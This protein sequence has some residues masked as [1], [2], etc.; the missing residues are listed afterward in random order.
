[1]SSLI[2][3]E[4]IC[5]VYLSGE[6][7]LYA[8]DHV[9]LTINHGEL[10]AIMGES[11]AGKS[12]LMDIVGLLDEPT[13]GRYRLD[14]NNVEKL[15]SNE[16]AEIRNRQIGFVFQSFFLLPRMT[17]VQNVAMPLIYRGIRRHRAEEYA[18][19]IMQKLNIANFKDHKPSQMS[20][21]EQQ[22]VAISRAL[23]GNPGVLLADE[24]TGALDSKTGKEILNLFVELQKKDHRTI[25]VVTHDAAVGAQCERIIV[26]R[27]GKLIDDFKN[28][29]P[30]KEHVADLVK[31]LM[32]ANDFGEEH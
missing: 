27:D 1:L 23:V 28:E 15:L 16:R 17:A 9:S 29:H 30:G 32:D 7:E 12:T 19:K 18:L 21:G 22:R 13:L 10:V 24:P 8:L 4:D 14:G 25:I 3:L 2:E 31:H 11:G 5:K 20:G 6:T 26:L